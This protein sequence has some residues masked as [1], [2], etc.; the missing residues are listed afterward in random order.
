[1]CSSDLAAKKTAAEVWAALKA[2]F[3]GADRVRAARLGTL[4]GEFELLRMA[5]AESLDD[6]A[7]RLGGMAARYAALGSTLKDV[8]LVKK[9]L[10]SVPNRLYPAVAG[11]EQFCDVDDMVFEDVLGRVK[12]FSRGCNDAGRTEATKAAVS[13]CCT[14]WRSGVRA[15]GVGAVH[16]ERTTTMVW[17]A[18]HQAAGTIAAGSAT[19]AV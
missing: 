9:L 4:R 17:R 18:R 15:S 16:A 5:D 10:D 7:G 11:I 8:A 19:S 1:M 14:P 3:V 12:A 6:F 2:R 13:S